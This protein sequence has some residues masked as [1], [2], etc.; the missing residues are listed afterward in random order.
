VTAPIPHLQSSPDRHARPSVPSGPAVVS[1]KDVSAWYGETPALE[2]VSLEVTAGSLVAV[3]GPN[4]AGKSTLLKLMA[5]VVKP[6]SGTVSVFGRSAGET[7]RR[8]AYV[9]QAELVD[10]HFPVS[11]D[12]VVM[13]GRYPRLGPFRR[14]TRVDGQAVEVALGK[15]GMSGL[16]DRQIGALSGGQR[17]RVF[18]ARALASEADLFLL[19]EPVTAIDATTQEEIM[20]LLAEEAEHG[21]TVIASTHD[22]AC[23]AQCFQ[24]VIA[25]NRTIVADG[26]S[27][28]ALDTDVLA[29]AYGG[30]LLM[31][32]DGRVILDDAHHHDAPPERERHFHEDAP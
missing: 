18:L 32:G 11:V 22:L 2:H 20:D 3:V 28:I 30:H 31:I 10:W 27:S 9:P 25:V 17:R 13:M 14:A 24:R 29:R 8:I 21:R 12:Q 23:A 4:G 15:V 26:P 5:G 7:G 1:L 6:H 16:A 19:D